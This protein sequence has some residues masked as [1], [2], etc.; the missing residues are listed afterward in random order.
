MGGLLNASTPERRVVALLQAD[1]D[2]YT[3]VGGGHRLQHAS[4]YQLATELPVM[5]DRRLQRQRPVARRSAQ[6]QQ[7]V[8]DGEIHYF[9]GGGGSAVAATAAAASRRQ[10]VEQRPD[11][12]VGGGV[13]FTAEPRV[14]GVDRLR[15]HSQGGTVAHGPSAADLVT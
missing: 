11:R 1:A 9:I 14:D 15:P 7:Y 8:A 10:R 4:G 3:W 2:G 6:F 12:R 5:A 13:S